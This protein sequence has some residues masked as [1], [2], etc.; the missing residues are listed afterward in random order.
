M[1]KQKIKLPTTDSDP[2]PDILNNNELKEI[3]KNQ[4]IIINNQN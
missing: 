4:N 1:V 3:I 2:Q